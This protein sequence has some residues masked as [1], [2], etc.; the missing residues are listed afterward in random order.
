MPA[1][2]AADDEKRAVS[3]Q[4]FQLRDATPTNPGRRIL[5]RR[6][7]TLFNL[8]SRA[9]G[10]ANFT[11]IDILRA[12]NPGIDDVDMILAGNTLLFPDPGPGS[13]VVGGGHE[14]AV[15]A[16]TTPTLVQAQG[17]QRKLQDQYHQRVE[18]EPTGTGEGRKLYRVFLRDFTGEAQ[19]K[20]VA[21]A[22]GSILHDPES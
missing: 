22:L 7:D 12:A 13:R 21:E 10:A 18:I 17:V 19:A 6:G 2:Q 15:L 14:V 4:V 3:A 9:Y 16:I 1:A 20:Q 8:A 5:V 11:T